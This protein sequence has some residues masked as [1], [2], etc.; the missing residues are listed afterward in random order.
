[1][2]VASRIVLVSRLS[3]VRQRP[4][5]CSGN[6]VVDVSVTQR[7]SFSTLFGLVRS[8]IVPVFENSTTLSSAHAC[9]LQI[10]AKCVMSGQLSERTP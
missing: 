9:L 5:S 1:V 7:A 4:V 8:K 2:E 10:D 6:K 3:V